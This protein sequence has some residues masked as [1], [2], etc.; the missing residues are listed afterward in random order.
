MIECWLIQFAHLVLS[1]PQ[2]DHRLL[3]L[4]CFVQGDDRNQVFSI[5][6][7]NNK[8]ISALKKAIKEEQKPTLDHVTADSLQLWKVSIPVD[9]NSRETLS[10][11]VLRDEEAVSPVKRLTDVFS[12][13]PKQGDLHVIKRFSILDGGECQ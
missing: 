3:E 12:D 1:V 8:P 6:I 9:N 2:A 5:E 4:N 7:P 11:I 10:Q 13:R